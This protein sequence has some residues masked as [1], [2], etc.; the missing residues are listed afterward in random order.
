MAAAKTSGGSGSGS[1]SEAFERW[2]RQFHSERERWGGPG[3][4]GEWGGGWGG[5]GGMW[6]A[7]FFEGGPFA[8][9]WWFQLK[10]DND[11]QFF[12]GG[13]P[14]KDARKTSRFRGALVSFKI[15]DSRENLHLVY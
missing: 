13:D 7:L 12:L 8:I 2:L 11:I 1:D 14:K 10:S 4:D 5:G 6:V 3:T 15:G 9:F